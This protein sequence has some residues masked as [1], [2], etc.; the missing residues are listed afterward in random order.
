MYAVQCTAVDTMLAEALSAKGLVTSALQHLQKHLAFTNTL[1][2][3]LYIVQGALCHFAERPHSAPTLQFVV[4]C[5]WACGFKPF[6]VAR[7]AA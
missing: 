1:S 4:N 3:V 6:T 7:I 5:T 2:Q